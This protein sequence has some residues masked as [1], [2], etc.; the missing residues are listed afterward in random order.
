MPWKIYVSPDNDPWT[1]LAREE[2]LLDHL[3][4]DESVFLL[5]VNAS[6]VVLGKNQNPW[7]ET[8]PDLLTARGIPLLRRISGGGTVFHDPGNLNYS[9]MQPKAG[10]SRQENLDLLT[11]FLGDSQQP[12]SASD[13]GDLLYGGAKCGG[14]ALCHRRAHSL[15]HGTILF[16][17]D[18][19]V[20]ADLLRPPANR[21]LISTGHQ[22]LSRPMVTVNLKGRIPQADM[23]GLVRDLAGFVAR[24]RTA[25]IHPLDGQVP[26]A[27]QARIV[28]RL[29]SWD[30]LYG[31]T[32]MFTL[33]HPAGYSARVEAGL[34]RSVSC[35]GPEEMLAEPV[36]FAGIDDPDRLATQ[37]A[38]LRAGAG[39]TCF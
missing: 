14:T 3:A 13:K 4:P 31:K 30:W 11:R 25:E 20:L 22:V 39:P 35:G 1:N 8:R 23:A 16:D 37:L 9:F 12:V 2:Y 6:C 32:P 18:L 29:Q 26:A 24:S 27:D 15:Q 28:E 34:V 17:S 7:W 19:A 38:T 5:Y 10:F 21:S 33:A 36:R